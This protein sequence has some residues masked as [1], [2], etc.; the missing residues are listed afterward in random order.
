MVAEPQPVSEAAVDARTDAELPADVWRLPEDSDVALFGVDRSAAGEP[1]RGL[2]SRLEDNAD[3][4][5]RRQDRRT[6]GIFVHY[7]GPSTPLVYAGYQETFQRDPQHRRPSTIRSCAPSPRAVFGGRRLADHLVAVGWQLYER[8]GEAWAL[9]L[10]GLFEVA[11]VLFLMVAGRQRRRSV[12]APTVGMLAHGGLSLAAAGL[13]AARLARTAP[14]AL[15]YALVVLVGDRPRV[16]RP[17]GEHDPAAAAARRR[18]SPTSTRGWSSPCSWRRSSARPPAAFD[19][20]RHRR[21]DR[22][23]CGGRRWPRPSS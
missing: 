12:S 15:I 2:R 9:G 21:R 16:R 1:D 14:V 22:G 7:R 20:R 23:V 11:P 18:C 17:G 6:Q 10:V 5:N 3:N 13:A 8:T 4:E 19:D